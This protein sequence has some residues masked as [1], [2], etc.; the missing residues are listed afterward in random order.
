MIRT[1]VAAL[2]E[3]MDFLAMH[4]RSAREFPSN[5]PTRNRAAVEQL[6]VPTL[7]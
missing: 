7:R 2:S 4:E 3:E 6:R 5:Q 1:K